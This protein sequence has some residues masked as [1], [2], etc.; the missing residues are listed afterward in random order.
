M[1]GL[2]QAIVIY[3]CALVM[4]VELSLRV[5]DALFVLLGS[6]LLSTFSLAVAAIVK[7]RERFNAVRTS[8]TGAGMAYRT[9]PPDGR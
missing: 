4:H 5:G 7:T 3:R 9:D 2:S 1:R 6:A 8:T